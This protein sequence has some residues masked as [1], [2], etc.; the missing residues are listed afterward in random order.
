MKESLGITRGV[1]FRKAVASFPVILQ[2]LP[3]SQAGVPT[4]L[5]LKSIH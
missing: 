2:H 5:Y 3:V 1:L 4:T